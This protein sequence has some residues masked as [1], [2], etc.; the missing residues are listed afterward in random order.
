MLLIVVSA[1]NIIPSVFLLKRT[2]PANCQ[3]AEPLVAPA[4][5]T[6]SYEPVNDVIL[7]TSPLLADE[8]RTT[9]VPLVAV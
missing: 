2:P 6:P 4:P 1:L 5:P 3:S 7:I 9:E 8:P